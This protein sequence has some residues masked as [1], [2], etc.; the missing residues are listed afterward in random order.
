MLASRSCS[1]RATAR[2]AL[3]E[4]TR[5]GRPHGLVEAHDEVRARPV[6]PRLLERLE[7]QNLEGARSSSSAL[8]RRHAAEQAPGQVGGVYVI[9]GSKGHP[10][11][12]PKRPRPRREQGTCR[13]KRRHE[14]CWTP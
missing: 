3:P 4:G 13:E 6:A 12:P 2:G 10:H 5:R 14:P 11:P 1:G 7:R 8:R 9:T